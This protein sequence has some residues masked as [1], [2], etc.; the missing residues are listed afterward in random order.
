MAKQVSKQYAELSKKIS[1]SPGLPVTNPSMPYWMD[2]QSP[3]TKHGRNSLLPE[4]AD[5]VIIGSGITGTA[6]VRTIL[7]N[8]DPNEDKPLTIVMLEARDTCSGATARN[9]GHIT[10]PL[11]H[12]Y[13]D[14]KEKYGAETAKRIIRFRLAHLENLLEVA[15]EEDLLVDSQCRRVQTYD[16]FFNQKLFD[17]CKEQLAI[18]MA[19]LPAE[20]ANYRVIEDRK[21]LKA[22]ELSPLTVG[23][24][25]TTAGAVHPYRLVTG[26]LSRLLEEYSDSFQLFTHTPC[27]SVEATGKDI[28]FIARTPRGSIKARHIVHA[29]NGWS[30]HLLPG[31]RRKIVPARGDMTAQRPGYGLG[32]SVDGGE[33]WTG[34]RSFV[35]YGGEA[36]TRYDYLTQQPPPRSSEAMG[37]GVEKGKGQGLASAGEM[38]FGGGF[39]QGGT[40][41]TA[42]FESVGNVDDRTWNFGVVSFLSGALGLYFEPAWGREQ[43]EETEEANRKWA[44]GRIK[45]HWSGIL[46]LSADGCPWVGRVPEKISKRN[47]KDSLL[48]EKRTLTTNKELS[49]DGEWICAGYTGEGMAH[50]WMSGTALAQMILGTPD[51]RTVGSDKAPNWFP[52]V[53]LISEERWKKA[54]VDDWLEKV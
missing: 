50:A 36:K 44:E 10:P 20:G 41:D 11:Y 31:M 18:Y 30:S 54:N 46:G 47:S 15:E 37:A 16:V 7:D 49:A 14:L 19:D 12:D 4:Y 24:M 26:I 33:D 2:P 45:A 52:E 40:A 48:T 51:N 42:F 28:P 1:L 43:V 38:M 8:Y 27:T 3:I 23:C 21:G 22:L 9:G 39:L 53:Y 25:E 6:I 35:F 34:Q 29:T 5:I 13:S 17:K 32:K